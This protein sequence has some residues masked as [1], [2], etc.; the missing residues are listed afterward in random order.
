MLNLSSQRVSD[1]FP[2]QSS[3]FAKPWFRSYFFVGDTLLLAMCLS[4]LVFV[5]VRY[6]TRLP[7][8]AVLWF[9]LVSFAMVALWVLALR[10]YRRIS[11]AFQGDVVEPIAVDSLLELAMSTAAGMIHWGLFFAYMMTAGVLM[12]LERV[13][14]SH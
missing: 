11:R 5:I 7:A 3:F 10:C 1:E 12:Q 6:W 2:F 9:G 4:M 14:A 13:L 8:T